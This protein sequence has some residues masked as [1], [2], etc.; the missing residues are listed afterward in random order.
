EWRGIAPLRCRG[1]IVAAAPLFTPEWRGVVPLRC[2][3]LIVAAVAAM[4]HQLRQRPAHKLQNGQNKTGQQSC[5]VLFLSR[6]KRDDS[7]Q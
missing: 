7:S 6:C 3:G 4:S 2:R 1:L 5:P